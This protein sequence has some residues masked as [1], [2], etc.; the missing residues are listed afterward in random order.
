M[1][2]QSRR[3]LSDAELEEQAT[4]YTHFRKKMG[5][6]AHWSISDID[7]ED[8]HPFYGMRWIESSRYELTDNHPRVFIGNAITWGD[9]YVA[10]NELIRQAEGIS[11]SRFVEDFERVNITSLTLDVFLGS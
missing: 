4:R 3:E 6:F 10:C 1:K 8:E 7:F 2:Y 11:H 9:L 5:L